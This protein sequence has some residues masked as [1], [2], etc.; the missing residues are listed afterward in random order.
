MITLGLAALLAVLAWAAGATGERLK[1]AEADRDDARRRQLA[2][3]YALAN[4]EALRGAECRCPQSGGWLQDALERACAELLP[5]ETAVAVTVQAE[6]VAEE[7]VVLIAVTEDGVLRR[8]VQF[9]LQ[10]EDGGV[11]VQDWAFEDI[12]LP[13]P[14]SP[15][16]GA[17]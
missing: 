2:A 15:E 12:D 13:A 11:A 10:A 6:G 1:R 5:G 17:P 3:E 16:W 4:L 14:D 8:S 7:S 9:P